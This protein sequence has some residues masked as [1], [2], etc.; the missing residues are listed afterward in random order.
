M[1]EVTQQASGRAGTYTALCTGGADSCV[2]SREGTY[3]GHLGWY[4]WV[5]PGFPQGR[6]ALR[7]PCPSFAAGHPEPQPVHGRHGAEQQEA[8]HRVHQP[9]RELHA[10]QPRPGQGSWNSECPPLPAPGPTPDSR[11]GLATAVQGV[12]RPGCD[13]ET[14]QPP[15]QPLDAPRPPP[16]PLFSPDFLQHVSPLSRSLGNTSCLVVRWEWGCCADTSDQALSF[17]EHLLCVGL[18][19]HTMSGPRSLREHLLCVWL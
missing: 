16:G 12:R 2:D 15:L 17:W 4:R 5:A 9:Q 18:W 3:R 8:P 14:L 7:T 1:P 13:P 11:L 10:Q 6:G 19:A